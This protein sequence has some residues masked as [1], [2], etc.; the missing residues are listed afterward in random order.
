[1]R[2]WKPSAAANARGDQGL[3]TAIQ[4][5]RDAA[6]LGFDWPDAEPVWDKLAEEVAEL[7]EAATSGDAKHIAH[8][9]GDVLFSV[10]NLARFLDVD[11]TQS[12]GAANARFS[13]R[14]Q[15]IQKALDVQGRSWDDCS[16]EEL[17]ALWQQAKH[18]T[19]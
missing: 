2:R 7:R 6:Q 9:L 16:L 8:E 17:E 19:G 5:Q 11:P 15:G 18:S 1:M 3:Q 4:L 13:Q 14:L 10:V 12:M